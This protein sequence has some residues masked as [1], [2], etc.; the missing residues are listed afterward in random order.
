MAIYFLS[1]HMGCTAQSDDIADA[2]LSIDFTS[3][4][5]M[6]EVIKDELGGMLPLQTNKIA[7][8]AQSPGAL[9]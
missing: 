4:L 5:D 3:T 8:E 7:L 9:A 2:L 1:L 6:L